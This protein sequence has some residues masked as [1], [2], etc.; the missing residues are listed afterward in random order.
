MLSL[1]TAVL[2]VV[3]H[4]R[5]HGLTILG[6]AVVVA[7]LCFLTVSL[8]TEGL[9]YTVRYPRTVVGSYL[10]VYLLSAAAIAS[11]LGYWAARNRRDVRELV[12]SDHL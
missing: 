10:F 3:D 12:R 11:G 8:G 1:F 5:T 6:R 9:V 4:S 7:V 2:L